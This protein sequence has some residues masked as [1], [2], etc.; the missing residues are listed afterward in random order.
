MG[1]VETP[2][3]AWDL[4]LVGN[5]AYLAD[6]SGGL[7]IIDVS[8]AAAPTIIGSVDTPRSS[9]DVTVVGDFA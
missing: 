6:G 9:E 5:L 4:V 3:H 2:G 7:Q 8:N 1:G